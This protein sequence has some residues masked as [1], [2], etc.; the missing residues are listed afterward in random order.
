MPKGR[1]THF[2]VCGLRNSE[3]SIIG[4]PATTIR[5]ARANAPLKKDKADDLGMPIDDQANV[6]GQAKQDRGIVQRK[7]RVMDNDVGR[8]CM[9]DERRNISRGKRCGKE[10]AKRSTRFD[11]Y[12][13]Y[14][15][16]TRGT[17]TPCA[18]D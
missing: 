2:S 8:S 6:I 4:C 9:A 12:A 5:S 1:T 14:R 11:R 7:R 13:V 18:Q 17:T 16:L 3:L 15:V 10:R